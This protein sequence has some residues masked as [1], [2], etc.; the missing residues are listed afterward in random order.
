MNKLISIIIVNYNGKKWL[1]KC[2]DSLFYQTYKNFEIIFVDNASS[3]E[4]VEFVKQYYPEVKIIINKE[5][6]G[7][8][9]G[10]N[11]GYENSKGEYILLLNNDTVVTKDFLKILVGYLDGNK[12]VGIVQPKIYLT[13]GEK[14]LDSTGSFLTQ[15]GFLQHSGLFETD[16]GQYDEIRE[17]F[18]A[19]GACMLIKKE[20][21]E[22]IGFLDENYFAYFEETDLCWR[23]WLAGY[24]TVFLPKAVIYHDMGL[25]VRKLPSSFIDYHSFKNRICTL[26][27]NLEAKNLLIIM[28]IHLFC[29]AGISFLFFIKL[30]FRNSW[31]IWRA[32]GWNIRHLEEI[33]QKRANVQKHIRLVTDKEIFKLLNRK[34]C[35]KD[36]LK[37]LKGYLKRW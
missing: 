32:I 35:F 4:S 15:T 21:I 2:L 20:L 22:K 3:D 37:S 16:H 5:N 8:A 9:G 31:A 1:K 27:K 13:R 17:I 18:S 6:L 29:C 7:F 30:K 19:K 23:T 11:V 33:Y 26:I 12:D 24:K 34:T 25:T 36:S 28:P 10:N 14:L